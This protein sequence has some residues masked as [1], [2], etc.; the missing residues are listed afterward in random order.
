MRNVFIPTTY[1]Q[2]LVIFVCA[3]RTTSGFLFYSKCVAPPPCTC[4]TSNIECNNKH[5]PEVP[6]FK[7]HNEHDKEIS[8]RLENNMLT[9]IPAY[10]FMNLSSI[11]ATFINILLFNN[12]ISSI[13]TLAFGGIENVLAYLDLNKNNLT[14]LPQAITNLTSLQ[15]LKILDNPLVSLDAS[16]LANSRNTLEVFDISIDRFASFP[17]ELGLLTT[18]SYL[19]ITNIKVPVSNSTVFH[20]FENTLTYLWM[21]HTVFD[22]IPAAVCRLNSLRILIVD[23]S[24]NLSTHTESIFDECNNTFSHLIDLNLSINQL[25]TIPKFGS[26]FP[27]IE[28]LSLRGNALHFIESSSFIGLTHL[29]SLE[30]DDNKFTSIPFAV[31]KASHLSSLDVRG[32]MIDTIRDMDLSN[33]Q[34]LT[35]LHLDNNPLVNVSTS[36][37]TNNH[38]LQEIFMRSS[39]LTHIP[40]AL[41]GLNNLNAVY[42]SGNPINCSCQAMNYL[43]SWNVT[44]VNVHATCRSGKSVKTYLVTNLPK[45]Q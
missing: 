27:R 3:T 23:Y 8:V 13:D 14:H 43:K 31:S 2:V 24:P 4:S 37:F 41:L 9:T 20:G 18:L 29:R 25:T 42:L 22:H 40:R 1:F 39:N 19:T 28:S 12:H 44:S 36:A 35:S 5:L 21:S 34:N 38:L 33:L 10:A 11:N 30:I 32:N 15:T 26:T 16:V 7:T 45:C 6:A 17:N